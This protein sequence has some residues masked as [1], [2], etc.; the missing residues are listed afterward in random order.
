MRKLIVS[1]R[2]KKDIIEIRTYISE[3]NLSAAKNLIYT[4]N[5]SLKNLCHTPFMGSIRSEFHPQARCL[6]VGKYLV[7]YEVL[8]SIVYILRILHS[9]RDIPPT[10]SAKQ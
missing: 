4:L 3:R 6:V 8:E 9:A 5:R 2:A 1:E 7:F 10:L